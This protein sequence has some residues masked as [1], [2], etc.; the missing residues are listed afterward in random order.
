ML[1]WHS[2][3]ISTCRWW[4]VISARG[5]EKKILKVQL[6]FWGKEESKV[7]YLRTQIQWNLF[8]EKL[9][10]WDWPLQRDTPWNSQDA[11]GT[12]LKFGKEKGNLEEFSKKVNSYASGF[13]EWTLEEISQQADCDNKVA[14]NLSSNAQCSATQIKLRYKRTL[15]GEDP[16]TL[17]RYWPW[18]VQ[19]IWTKTHEFFVRD[20]DLFVTVWWLDETPSVL[21]L[22][23]TLL[24]TR[25]PIGV[26]NRWNSTIGPKL[27]N[28]V[29]LVVPGM[30][31]Y[32][33]RR[34]SP[35]PR[36]TDQ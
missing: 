17:S 11:S 35:R 16:G 26:E 10:N 36:S 14:W 1:L 8:C 19:C 34:L 18:L 31:S 24:K 22:L 28:F 12:R 13:K 29:H 33:I 2:L 27:G 21:L 15:R 6:L 4:E 9:E 3:P 23:K 25:I 30:S 32:S 7:V 5:R 20:F